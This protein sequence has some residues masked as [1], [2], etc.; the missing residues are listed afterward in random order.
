MIFLT[1]FR[2]Y[3][4]AD[5]KPKTPLAYSIAVYQPKWY[6]PLPETRVF[7][8]RTPDGKWTR[9][10][11]FIPEGHDP[12][13]P[14]D[15]LLAQYRDVLLNLYRGRAEQIGEFLDE[16]GVNTGFN[17]VLCCWCPYDR[18][19]KRQ[20]HDYGSFVCHSAVVELYLNEAGV[21]NVVRDADREQM[22]RF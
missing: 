21:E 19:A 6:P 18:A 13:Q 7:D 10:R 3:F 14:S 17:V 4:E 1:S 2:R 20:L 11:D 5:T 15:E 8:I 12:T 16:A 9:P 22:V